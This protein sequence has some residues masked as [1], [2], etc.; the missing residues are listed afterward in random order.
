MPER[1]RTRT[2]LMVARKASARRDI[3]YVGGILWNRLTYVNG[4]Y[5]R[6]LLEDLA[7][8]DADFEI[9]KHIARQARSWSDWQE[10]SIDYLIELAPER[11]EEWRIGTDQ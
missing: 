10:T 1:E 11:R 8:C 6:R 4:K 2:E 3:A 9:V 5:M 7:E